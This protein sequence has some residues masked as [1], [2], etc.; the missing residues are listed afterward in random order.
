MGRDIQLVSYKHTLVSR[1]LLTST[2]GNEWYDEA[3]SEMLLE[4]LNFGFTSTWYCVMGGAQE[5]AKRQYAAVEKVDKGRVE[6]GKKVV[7]LE[8][9]LRE[10]KKGETYFGRKVATTIA[11]EQKPRVYDAVF[12]SVP[13]GSMQR[14]DLR[15]LNLNWGTKQAIRSLA[16]GASC[17]VGVRFKNMWWKDLGINQG[18]V[19]KTDLPLRMCVYP[20]HNKDDPA[21]QPAVLLVSY[22]WSQEAQRIATLINRKS[23]AD[24]GELRTLLVDNLAR[25]H[26]DNPSEIE[27]LN[28]SIN[29]AWDTHFAYDWYSDAGTTGAFAY[30]GP[31]Q[32]RNMYP[33]IVRNDGSHIIIGEAASA[34]HAWVVGALESAVRGVYQFLHPHSKFDPKVNEVLQA[35]NHNEIPS[36]YGPVPAEFD[37]TKDVEPLGWDGKQV[38]KTSAIGEWL[39]QG[40]VAEGI[41]L[42]QGG[43]RLDTSKV[44]KDQVKEFLT[45]QT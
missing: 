12:N 42:E 39:R 20:S 1:G 31:G 29:A 21:D 28:I 41:R 16:Y 27:R 35:Y 6:F 33:Y 17:K 9:L 32:F 11:G 23:P 3:L 45:V 7:K 26:A 10:A 24:E 40:V 18:G 44:K 8:Y 13:L 15:G 2:S 14:M 5:I 25:L 37:R 43:E 34:H 36:P 30:L 19:S 22:S 38:E 4:D